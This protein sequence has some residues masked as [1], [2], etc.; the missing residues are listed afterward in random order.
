[1]MTTA[2]NRTNARIRLAAI[3]VCAG[4]AL[5]GT[6]SIGAAS[7][8]S[9]QSASDSLPPTLVLT[10]NVRDFRCANESNGHADFERTP[11]GGY[12]HYVGEVEDNLDADGKPVF[13]GTGFKVNTQKKDA[14]GRNIMPVAKSYIDSKPGDTTPSIATS[15][16]GSTTTSANFAKWFR[17]TNGTNLSKAV[18][19]TLVRQGTSNLYSFSDTSD[20]TYAGKGGF[21]PINGD[22]FGNSSNGKNFGFSFELSTKFIFKRGTGQ[23][24]TFTGDDDVFVFIGGKL[25]VDIGGVHGATSQT[26]DLDRLNFLTDG[27]EYPLKLFFAE[28]H[29]TQSNVRIDTTI[30]L[31]PAELPQSS[32]LFD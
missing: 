24:F 9:G 20:A 5:P 25:V 15:A 21:F 26:I 27:Q 30:T 2:R 3:L 22:L 12:A 29:T 14:Q 19:L 1:M 6:M 31:T 8:G 17:D 11:T 16:G 28:R 4:C 7:D 32:G 18:P 23:V 13:K 10:G